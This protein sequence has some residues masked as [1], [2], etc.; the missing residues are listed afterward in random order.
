MMLP[1][2]ILMSILGTQFRDLKYVSLLAVQ[3]LFFVSPVMLAREVLSS[4]QL[5]LLNVL[6]PMAPLLHMFRE[7]T[8]QAQWWG[9]SELGALLAW[10]FIFW[11]L[12]AAATV[13]TG[14]RIIFHL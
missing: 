10:T 1:I 13:F 5:S 7:T 12:A 3:A 11:V 4:E 2:A 8:M 9:L 14:R 6:N